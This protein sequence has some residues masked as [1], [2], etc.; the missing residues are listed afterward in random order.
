MPQQTYSNNT[1]VNHNQKP[2]D[3]PTAW[4]S[5][6]DKLPNY[7][8]LVLMYWAGT[9]YQHLKNGVMFVGL[10]SDEKKGKYWDGC[11]HGSLSCISHWMLLPPIPEYGYNY[12]EEII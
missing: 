1:P 3:V 7:G 12:I 9:R 6:K 8:K 11:Q 4:I 5:I 10:V 2:H